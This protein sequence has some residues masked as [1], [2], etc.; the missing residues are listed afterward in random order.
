MVAAGAPQALTLSQPLLGMVIRFA[1]R[2]LIVRSCMWAVVA[3]VFSGCLTTHESI[4]AGGSAS[5]V[6]EPP[7]FHFAGIDSTV[8]SIAA[9]LADSSFVDRQR[10]EEARQHTFEGRSFVAEVDSLLSAGKKLDFLKEP[11]KPD[12]TSE[13]AQSGAVDAFNL[14]A[15]ALEEYGR[16]DSLQAADLLEQAQHHFEQALQLNPF[17][18][19]AR[20]WL[21]RVYHLRASHLG[22]DNEH[23]QALEI[24]LRLVQMHQDEHGLFAALAT[25]YEH[26]EQWSQAAVMW[27]QAAR[28]ALDDEEL[29]VDRDIRADS[30]LLMNYYVRSERAYVEEGDS[31]AA[32][33]VLD[34]A[35]R[36]AA[37]D[38]DLVFVA[39][40]RAWILWDEGNLETRKTWDELL[41]LSQSSPASAIEGMEALLGQLAREQAHLEVRH[42]LGLLYYET[43]QEERAAGSLQAL[44]QD[45]KHGAE[46]AEGES[47]SVQSS[48]VERIREDYGTVT[49]N[50]SHARY[51]EG[52]LRAALA[53]LLQSEETDCSLAAKAAFEAALLLKNNIDKALETAHRAEVRLAQL[54]RNEQ[55]KLLRYLVEL[56]RR[57]GDR[58]TALNYVQKY[59]AL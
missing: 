21:S 26:L 1:Y 34:A 30:S 51:Q 50:L 47:A 4:Q 46:D 32:L 2:H 56:Y 35:E 38:E 28:T 29:D 16:A 58:D 15:M 13:A 45:V 12:T 23:E 24:L 20:Y 8:A 54:E 48:L 31:R 42:R 10:Q 22:A 52:D 43:Q 49:Y 57:K 9:A 55:K 11:A 36:W 25:T 37:A 39:D 53:Y 44:W 40:E 18:A 17:D 6:H 33:D 5:V 59:H 19:E 41:A 14:G 27:R 7:I 3:L